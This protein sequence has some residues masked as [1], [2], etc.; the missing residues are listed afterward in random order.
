M[1]E[2]V[3]LILGALVIVLFYQASLCI[4]KEEKS[5]SVFYMTVLLFISGIFLMLNFTLIEQNNKLIERL[6][7]KCPEYEKL[8]NV[9]KI[10]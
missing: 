3:L 9:Y 4:M 1:R 2:A 10:K 8:N 5:R 7:N 6:K